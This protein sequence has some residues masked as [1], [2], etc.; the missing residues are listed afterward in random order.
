MGTSITE[1]YVAYA[2]ATSTPPGSTLFLG[3]SMPI[4]DVEMYAA[5]TLD[6]S[7]SAPFVGLSKLTAS[8][9]GASGIDGVLST[10]IGFAAG[11][12]R[13]VCIPEN[14]CFSFSYMVFFICFVLA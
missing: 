14:H 12:N 11:S 5:S 2:V 10:A 6:Q 3:N 9:R 7:F 1:P 4:R 8:N 13:R